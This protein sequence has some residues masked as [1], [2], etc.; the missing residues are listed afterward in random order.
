MTNQINQELTEDDAPTLS[1]QVAENNSEDTPE[2]PAESN[3]IVSPEAAKVLRSKEEDDI[4]KL[5]NSTIKPEGKK[6][7]I[8]KLF[9]L[10]ALNDLNVAKFDMKDANRVGFTG[11]MS[12]TISSMLRRKLKG[13][14]A[15]HGLDSEGNALVVKPS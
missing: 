11:R 2:L 10:A 3:S 12:M 7:E 6:V 13:G 14:E 8:H 15:I 4:R 1:E 5:I 9:E